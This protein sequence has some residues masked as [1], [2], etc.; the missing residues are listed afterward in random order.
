MGAFVYVSVI[1]LFDKGTPSGPSA[2]DEYYEAVG[3][4][5]SMYFDREGE[6]RSEIQLY[7]AH[8]NVSEEDHKV[9]L[10]ERLG[11]SNS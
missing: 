11:K 3:G 8:K 6:A 9:A 7:A 10:S 5:L 4:P 1:Y 2:V